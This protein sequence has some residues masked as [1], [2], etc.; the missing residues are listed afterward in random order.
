ML[1]VPYFPEA[2]SFFNSTTR[3][4]GEGGRR[5]RT[6][7]SH[8][9]GTPKLLWSGTSLRGTQGTRS[10]VVEPPRRSMTCAVGGRRGAS[11]AWSVGS[12]RSRAVR[13]GSQRRGVTVKHGERR[14]AHIGGFLPGDT[15]FSQVMQLEV[16]EEGIVCRPVYCTKPPTLGESMWRGGSQ[17]H[18][19]RR[20]IPAPNACLGTNIY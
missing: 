11:T 2:A 19:F 18:L 6:S 14:A 12:R 1:A 13:V 16:Y 3:A 5:G 17:R 9:H 4:D 8:L 15:G 10:S 20:S 7:L